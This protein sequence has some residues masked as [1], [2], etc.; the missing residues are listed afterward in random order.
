MSAAKIVINGET[1]EM[2]GGTGFTVDDTLTMSGENV[3]GVTTP[4][5]SATKAEFDSMSDEQK[6]GLVVVTDETAPVVPGVGEAYSADEVV[7]GKWIDGKPIYRKMLEGTSASNNQ[8]WADIE[9]IENLD[10]LVRGYGTIFK[11]DSSILGII[12]SGDLLIGYNENNNGFVGVYASS[13]SCYNKKVR[14]F[15][16]YTKTTDE[17][18]AA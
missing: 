17:G 6:Q 9:K 3:L 12:P 2:G 4:V 11:G 18:S 16:E 13:S 7:I 15:I 14:F 5:R 10:Y 1:V 8:R